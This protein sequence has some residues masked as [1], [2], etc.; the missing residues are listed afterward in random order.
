MNCNGRGKISEPRSWTCWKC[1]QF[2]ETF[3]QKN[4]DARWHI[5]QAKWQ[6]EIGALYFC[7]VLAS[8]WIGSHGCFI[9]RAVGGR[10]ARGLLTPTIF[11]IWELSDL[12]SACTVCVDCVVLCF[13]ILLMSPIKPIPVEE[14]LD[15]YLANCWAAWTRLGMVTLVT[16]TP[17]AWALNTVLAACLI[18]LSCWVQQ[19]SGI[20]PA[21]AR[22][23]PAGE[24]YPC[25]EVLISP[26]SQ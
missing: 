8:G 15:I 24:K 26:N 25:S 21:Q 1:K 10:L 7:W 3:L 18:G 16:I 9:I 11:Y 4:N 12:L 13:A 2:A 6:N 14:Y 20:R 5:W 23:G 17:L 19:S 22:R